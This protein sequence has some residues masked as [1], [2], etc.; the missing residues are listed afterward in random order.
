MLGYYINM[1]TF[2]QFKEQWYANPTSRTDN[3]DGSTTTTFTTP[4]GK[5]QVVNQSKKEKE[6]AKKLNQQNKPTSD[7]LW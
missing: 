4:D 3:S 6:E 1:K 2:K 5:K 7:S